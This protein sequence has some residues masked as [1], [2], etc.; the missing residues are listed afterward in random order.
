MVGCLGRACVGDSACACDDDALSQGLRLNTATVLPCL[1]STH[2]DSHELQV[3]SWED[4]PFSN[5][6]ALAAAVSQVC[7]QHLSHRPPVC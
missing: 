7:C 6:T 5:E 3:D 1:L 4:V 2:D